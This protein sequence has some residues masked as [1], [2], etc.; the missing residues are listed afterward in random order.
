MG[1]APRH[2]SGEES[3]EQDEEMERRRRVAWCTWKE[4]Y[5]GEEEEEEARKEREEEATCTWDEPSARWG[6]YASRLVGEQGGV[7]ETAPC[8]NRIGLG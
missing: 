2:R 6:E 8:R 3:T 1:P 7:V 4:E 5:E